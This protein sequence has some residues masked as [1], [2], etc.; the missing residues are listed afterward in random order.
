[1]FWWSVFCPVSV[2]VFSHG[3]LPGS[4]WIFQH[5]RGADIRR[6][7]Q[8]DCSNSMTWKIHWIYPPQVLQGEIRVVYTDPLPKMQ[9]TQWWLE[10]WVRG[11]RSK[12]FLFIKQAA[13]A[14]LRII[15]SP[16]WLW[17]G[18]SAKIA[19]AQVKNSAAKIGTLSTIGTLKK[20]HHWCKSLSWYKLSWIS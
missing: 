10:S 2:R 3:D 4:G 15:Q 8:S 14:C 5:P 20:C 7:Q 1:M 18:V 11:G 9:N 12:R 16:P 19:A 13:W 17:A 6:I